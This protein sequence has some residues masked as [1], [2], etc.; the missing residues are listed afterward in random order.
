M[1]F[2]LKRIYGG[3]VVI[4]L[5]SF[6]IWVMYFGLIFIFIFRKRTKKEMAFIILSSVLSWLLAQMT[7]D[8]LPTVRPFLLNGENPLTLTEHFD[9]SFPSGHSA[10]AFGLAT[11]LFLVDRNLG[12][13]YFVLAGF[14]SWGRVLSRVHF[15][16][17]V[18]GGA[19]IG[20]FVSL[21]LE[22]FFFVQRHSSSK[23]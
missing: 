19:V 7:K 20:I 16:V 14:V 15:L 10:T 21:L 12:I 22:N 17:D 9:N 6:L 11:S 8:L 23:R 5:A 18:L 4:F 3:G 2:V 13:F 1:D